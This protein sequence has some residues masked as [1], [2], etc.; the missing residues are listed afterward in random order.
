MFQRLLCYIKYAVIFYVGRKECG[1]L[2]FA[3]LSA[4]NEII[5]I[6]KVR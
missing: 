6:S 5:F 4:V 1:I 2:I 3:A